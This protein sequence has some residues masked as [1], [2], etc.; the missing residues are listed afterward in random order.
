MR[1]ISLFF[2]EKRGPDTTGRFYFYPFN[3]NTEHIRIGSLGVTELTIPVITHTGAN[4]GPTVLLVAGQHGNEKT[5]LFV[6]RELL[7]SL[8]R[9]PLSAG[10][11]VIIPSA[12]PLAMAFDTR[13]EPLDCKNLNRAFPGNPRKDLPARLAATLYQYV[14][15]ADLV[16]DLHTFSR[17][18]PLIGI[19]TEGVDASVNERARTALKAI[20]P[21]CIWKIDMTREEDRR[22][23]GALDILA[24]ENGIAAITL[25]MERHLT[26]DS[27]KI[28]AIAKKL[29]NLFATLGMTRALADVQSAP[30]PVYTAT[31]WYSDEAGIFLPAC[32]I[33]ENVTKGQTIAT[34]TSIDHFEEQKLPAP[35]DGTLL[36][37]RFKDI[38]RTGMKLGSFGTR[39][40]TW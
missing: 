30:L 2:K 15:V 10:R 11:L 33:L 5:P 24:T 16:V 32:R 35:M 29:E 37:I 9:S 23:A 27:A 40:E 39:V 8:E 21:D 26:I 4:N 28:S 20:A 31:Y 18:T 6:L 19:Y 38:V 36:T 17:Q 34:L 25:E 13:Q 14:R 3:M 1:K 7:A 12:N 22:F